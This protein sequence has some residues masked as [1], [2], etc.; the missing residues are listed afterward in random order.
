VTPGK[1]Y[2]KVDKKGSCKAAKSKTITG[3]AYY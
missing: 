2:A 3:P 1:Y